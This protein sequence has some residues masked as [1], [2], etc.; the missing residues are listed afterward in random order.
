MIASGKG[1]SCLLV[2]TDLENFKYFNRK[3]GYAAG[4]QLLREFTGYIIDTLKAQYCPFYQ[5]GR[6]SV[7]SLL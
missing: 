4:D 6:R 3:Y 1:K 7:H 5:G 2:Y